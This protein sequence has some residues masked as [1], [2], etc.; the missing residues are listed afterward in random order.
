MAQSL[1]LGS[2]FK[3]FTFN[4]QLET[5]ALSILSVLSSKREERE[6]HGVHATLEGVYGTCS[7]RMDHA[8]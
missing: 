2:S 1:N 3:N 8:T 4:L 7:N 5:P 6:V